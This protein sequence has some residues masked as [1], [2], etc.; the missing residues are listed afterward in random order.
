MLEVNERVLKF[1]EALKSLGKIEFDNDFCEAIDMKRQNLN[2]IKNQKNYFAT[3]HIYKICK[4]YDANANYFFGTEDN[5][6]RKV[7]K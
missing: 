2:N 5:M 3:K 6:F 1:I 4:V 7:K